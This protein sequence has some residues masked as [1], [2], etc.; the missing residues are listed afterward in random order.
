[1]RLLS[2]EWANERNANRW[3]TFS[4]KRQFL[5]VPTQNALGRQRALPQKFGQYVG[6]SQA[7]TF[8]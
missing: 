4:L 2:R 5:K 1:M 8:G 6:Y 7:L 3:P